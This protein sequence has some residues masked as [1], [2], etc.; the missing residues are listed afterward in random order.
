MNIIKIAQD[1][2]DNTV[3]FSCSRDAID[4]IK[5]ILTCRQMGSQGSS[6]TIVIEDWDEDNKFDFDGDGSAKI[7]TIEINGTKLSDKS[8]EAKLQLKGLLSEGVEK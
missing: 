8:S 6:R 3:T 5:L 4:L 7:G 1:S 2:K